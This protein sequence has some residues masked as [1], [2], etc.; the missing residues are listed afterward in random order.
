ME[1]LQTDTFEIELKKRIDGNFPI[2]VV[3]VVQTNKYY[4]LDEEVPST[5]SH[6]PELSHL[7]DL[8]EPT[9]EIQRK[10]T[11]TTMIRGGSICHSVPAT[12]TA[13]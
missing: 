1:R 6:P 10:R 7:D 2:R 3:Q 8:Q 12:S 5:A 11:S 9:L 4:G 13:L